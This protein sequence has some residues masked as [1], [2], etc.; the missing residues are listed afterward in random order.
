MNDDTIEV[1]P[2][3]WTFSQWK[4]FKT[5]PRQYYHKHVLKDIKFVQNEAGR[6]GDLVHSAIEDNIM[7]GTPI[8]DEFKKYEPMFAP[9]KLWKGENVCE[10]KLAVDKNLQPCDYYAPDYWCRGK[11]DFTNLRLELGKAKVLDWKTNKT[12][13]YAELKQLELMSLMLMAKHPEIQVVDAALC[14][15]VPNKPVP[16]KYE[17]KDAPAQWLRWQYEISRIEYAVAKNQ[18]GP[19]PNGLCKNFCSVLSCEHNGQM[20]T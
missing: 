3:T 15:L 12:A 4:D 14:F 9:V 11:A 13:K 5:C 1:K 6:Y 2:I 8:P 16:A 10:L 7:K 20:M 18:F 17:R 19:N